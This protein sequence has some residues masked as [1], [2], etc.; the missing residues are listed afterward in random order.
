MNTPVRE[1]PGCP[2]RLSLPASLQARG[3]V[4]NPKKGPDRGYGTTVPAGVR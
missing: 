1:C 3:L 2:A 4:N